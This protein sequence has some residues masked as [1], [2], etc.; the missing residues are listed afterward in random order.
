MVRRVLFFAYGVASYLV[1]FATFLYAVGF[2]GNFAV[3]ATLDGPRTAP[4]GRA[5]LVD[6]A[7]LGLFAVQHSV[8]AR[9][10]FKAR[11]TRL[12]PPE[13]ERSTYV[14][15]SSLAL[16]LLFALWEPLGG[17]VWSVEA[18][19]GRVVLYGLFALGFGLVLVSTFLINHFDLF[20]LRQAWLALR[21]RPYTPLRFVTPGPYRLVRHPLYVGWFFAFWSTPT[22]T[23]SHL[24]FAAATTAYILIAIQLEE[25]DLVAFH[26]SAYEEYRRRV[27]MLWPFR[28][29][30]LA[31]RSSSRGP[32]G[33]V[34]DFG[35]NNAFGE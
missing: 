31:S 25:R 1:F 19:A 32:S 23:L 24:L 28:A 17:S 4:L 2:I 21:G 7:L 18:F 3:P 26:G 6:V 15:F 11:W 29:G 30:S 34:E 5:L 12:V 13:I 9:R 33:M 20:G 14:L 27:P 16:L 10:W 8:M 22:M 35:T